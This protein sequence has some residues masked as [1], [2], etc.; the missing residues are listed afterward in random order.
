MYKVLIVDDEPL[1]QVGVKSM[2]NWQEYNMEICG[3]AVNGEVAYDLI[4]KEQPDLVIS[5]IKM[6]VM[7]GLALLRKCRNTFGY[8]KPLFIMLTSYEEFSMAKESVSYQATDYLL[9]VELTPESLTE[10]IQKAKTMLDKRQMSRQGNVTPSHSTAN[11]Y[12]HTEKFLISLLNNLFESEEQMRLQAEHL[13]IQLSTNGYLCCYGSFESSNTSIAREQMFSQYESSLQ[14][15]QKLVE[16]YIPCYTLALDVSHFAIIFR[17][18][19]MNDKKS[20]DELWAIILDILLKI[21]TSLLNYYNVRM[22]VGIGTYCAS[23]IALT[24]SFQNARLAYRKTENADPICYLADAKI[25]V[26]D[27]FNISL[28]KADLTKAFEEFDATMLSQTMGA[29]CDLIQ[30]HPHHF[31]QALDAASNIL[32]LSLSLLRDGETILND[33]FCNSAD[34]YLSLYKQ[35]S[36]DQVVNWLKQLS[37]ALSELFE[38]RRKDYKNHIVTDV[39]N[40]IQEHINE[41]LSLNEVAAQFAISSSYLSQL[42]GR[43]NDSGFSEY[44][45]TMKIQEAK[46]LLRDKHLKVYEVADILSFGSE[47]YFSKV[48]KKIEGISPTEYINN[49]FQ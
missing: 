36:V 35:T 48:F 12:S 4:Q 34:G 16:K 37:Q 42:F 21:R 43:Y 20:Q 23:T 38:E 46:H 13:K 31:V 32:Y 19:E 28:F 9:K 39:K 6:P 3:T 49:D 30:S 22:R 44:I 26:H 7:D 14:M 15:V 1:V 41:K 24:E 27:A 10:S 33:I 18:N 29:L 45:N 5:D 40:Y 17:F 11:L 2:I 25:V 8:E 47:F